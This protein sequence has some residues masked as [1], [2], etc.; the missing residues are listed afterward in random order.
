MIILSKKRALA[1]ASRNSAPARPEFLALDDVM[2]EVAFLPEYIETQFSSKENMRTRS[3]QERVQSRFGRK[4][5]DYG[6]ERD[7]ACEGGNASRAHSW[8]RRE[9]SAMNIKDVHLHHGPL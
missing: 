8:L 3:R 9:T 6:S 2:A 1:C 5:L 7:P 4:L